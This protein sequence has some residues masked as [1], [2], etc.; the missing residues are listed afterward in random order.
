MQKKNRSSR[1]IKSLRVKTGKGSSP[2]MGLDSKG[3]LA[4]FSFRS[5]QRNGQTFCIGALANLKIGVWEGEGGCLLQF[6]F[7][8]NVRKVVKCKR[9]GMTSY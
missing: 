5:M 2:S 8:Q 7:H 9:V 1:N 6:C 3:E 4:S